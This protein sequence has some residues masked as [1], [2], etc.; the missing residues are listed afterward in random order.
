MLLPGWWDMDD[1]ITVTDIP[2][3]QHPCKKE[4]GGGKGTEGG[5]TAAPCSP[6]VELDMSPIPII[7]QV[8]CFPVLLSQI[9]SPSGTRT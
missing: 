5:S 8:K 9:S 3:P 4:A 7:K 6:G 1:G 2:S